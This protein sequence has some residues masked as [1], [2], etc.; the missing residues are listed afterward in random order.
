MSIDLLRHACRDGHR[1]EYVERM[2]DELSCI[3]KKQI[4]SVPEDL[5][6]RGEVGLGNIL[7]KYSQ[8]IF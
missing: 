4:M 7:W 1:R 3:G 8:E 6:L 2:N 5:V